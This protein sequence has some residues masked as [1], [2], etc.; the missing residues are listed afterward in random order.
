MAQTSKPEEAIA[1]RAWQV[2]AL[3]VRHWPNL[4]MSW[5][6]WYDFPAH[7]VIQSE[8]MTLHFTDE[9]GPLLE[10]DQT[11]AQLAWSDVENLRPSSRFNRIDWTAHWGTPVEEHITA[12]AVIYAAIA[13]WVGSDELPSA[14][15]AKIVFRTENPLEDPQAVFRLL[16]VFPSLM[17]TVQWYASQVSVG[18]RRASAGRFDGWHEPLWQIVQAEQTVAVFD[19]AGRVHL[20]RGASGDDNFADLLELVADDAD[21]V[22]G[23]FSFDVLQ[24]LGRVD[25]DVDALV[26]LIKPG[27]RHT[28]GLRRAWNPTDPSRVRIQPR[29]LQY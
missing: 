24:A 15:P 5:A 12:K 20:P 6:D 18:L 23:G 28:F 16:G 8:T 7:L 27:A 21:W 26:E 19:E 10:V 1:A 14:R 9:E 11:D 22:A 3:I 25:G 13:G 29:R 2:A 4:S 17:S